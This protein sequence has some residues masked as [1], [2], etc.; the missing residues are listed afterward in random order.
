MARKNALA[1]GLGRIEFLLGDW[2]EPVNGRSFDLI[3][4]N[5]PYIAADDPVLSTGALRHE[6]R[7]ALTPGADALASLLSITRAASRY[8]ER[9]GWLLLEHG[10]EQAPAVARELVARGFRYVRSHRDLA[11]HERMTEAQR[12]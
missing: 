11:G 5:P 10:A 7:L 4:S 9:H 2:L 6:P 1:L 8:L 3:V 12:N